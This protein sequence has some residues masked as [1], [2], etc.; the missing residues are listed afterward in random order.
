M[1]KQKVESGTK[2]SERVKDCC[3]RNRELVY[4]RPIVNDTA[5]MV[6]YKGCVLQKTSF[7]ICSPW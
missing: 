7:T 3:I 2:D 6:S 4:D 5:S 1:V